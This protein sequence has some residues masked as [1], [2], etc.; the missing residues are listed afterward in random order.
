M[1]NKY[2]K[3]N[4]NYSLDRVEKKNKIKLYITAYRKE[5]DVRNVKIKY[6]KNEERNELFTVELYGYDGKLKY[7]TNKINCIEHIIELI[8]KMPMGH[9]ELAERIKSVELYTDAHKSKTIQGLGFK[10]KD[11]AI[12]SILAVSKLPIDQ[13]FKIINVLYQ[14]AKYHPYPTEG[15]KD[16]MKVFKKWLDK[17]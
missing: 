9:E 15:I 7:K 16:A 17:K 8:D 13:Q 6:I 2:R 12:K 4:I 3:L 5:L 1:P 10:N 14:R 11:S